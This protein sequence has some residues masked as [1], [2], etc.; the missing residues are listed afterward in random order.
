MTNLT[1]TTTLPRVGDLLN[2]LKASGTT[3]TQCSATE[4]RIEGHGIKAEA[5]YADPILTVAVLSKPFYVPMSAI[6]SGIQEHLE[7]K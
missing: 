6:Q 3:V 5:K 4:F 1:F 2:Q 7:A